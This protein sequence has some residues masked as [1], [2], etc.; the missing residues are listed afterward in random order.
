MERNTEKTETNLVEA[1][2]DIRQSKA[3]ASEEFS[4]AK[5]KKS[6]GKKAKN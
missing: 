1:L 5:T 2:N 3:S 6:S 4:R